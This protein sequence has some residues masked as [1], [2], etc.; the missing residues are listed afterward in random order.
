MP[1]EAE[2]QKVSVAGIYMFIDKWLQV[3]F[4]LG[5]SMNDNPL[6]LFEGCNGEA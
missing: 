6:L 5:A 4:L 2:I 1:N 3:Q